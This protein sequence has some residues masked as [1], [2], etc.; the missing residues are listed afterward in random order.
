[1]G[2][3]PSDHI[4]KIF[5]REFIYVFLP[6]VLNGSCCCKLFLKLC[7][8]YTV[9]ADSYLCKIVIL[10]VASFPGPRLFRLH[11]GKSQGLG[12]LGLTCVRPRVKR[13]LSYQ[14]VACYMF[15]CKMDVMD[16]SSQLQ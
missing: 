5:P 14:Y 4:K 13:L 3:V 2:E 12:S 15:R 6:E 11:E 1:M 7:V 9:V 8:L 10:Y 16:C